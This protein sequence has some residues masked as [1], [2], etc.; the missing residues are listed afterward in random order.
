MSQWEQSQL[1]AGGFVAAK[2]KIDP[3]TTEEVVARRYGGAALGERA[4]VR[5]GADRLGPAEDLAMEYLGL[6]PRGT[7]AALGRQTKRALGF[8]N[9]ALTHHRAHAKYALQLIKR[10]KAAARRAKSKP[11]HAWDE[12]AAMADELNKSVRH[13]LPA[14]WEEAAR[15]YK[16]LGNQTYAGRSLN[17]ALEAERV[18]A[19]DVDREHRRDAVLEFTLGG[20]LSGKALSEYAA[21]LQNQFA[22]AEAFAT[23]RDLVVR[24]TLGGMAPTATMGK[25]LLRVAKA[26]GLDADAEVESVLAEI[27]ASPA[28]P[29]TP[30]QFWESVKPHVKRIVARSSQFA[31]WLLV[32]TNPQTGYS[33]DSTVWP[34]L[35]LLDEWNVLPWLSAEDLPAE[36]EIPGGRAGWIG[37]LARVES[38]PD[39]RVLELLEQMADVLR[40]EGQPV[41]LFE[42]PRW[43]RP[44]VDVDVLE[45]CLDLGLPLNDAPEQ[46]EFDFNG[47]LRAAVDHPRRNS[48]LQRVAQDERFAEHVR[49][50]IPELV[51]FTGEAA[52]SH[53]TYGR[54]LPPRRSFEEAATGHAALHDAWWQYL[55]GLLAALAA[56]GLPDAEQALASLR[57]CVGKRTNEQFPELLQRLQK[58]DLVD[59]LQRTIRAGV[60]DEY[61]WE[62]LEQAAEQHKLQAGSRR[63]AQSAQWVFPFVAYRADNQV[64]VVRPDRVDPPREL[65]LKTSQDLRLTLPVGDDVA[66]GYRDTSLGW[67]E[68]LFWLSDPTQEHEPKESLYWLNPEAIVPTEGGAFYGSRVVKPGDT[69]LPRANLFFHDGVRFWRVK[70]QVRSY[71][72]DD[73]P[74]PPT[75]A[76]IDP[77]TGKETRD[78]VPSWFEEA[79][80]A[81]ATI[82]WTVSRLLP[83]P[84][85]LTS[86]P[87]GCRD[88]LIG[89]KVMRRR[90]RSVEGHGI[91]GRRFSFRELRDR[92]QYRELVPVAMMDQP[93]GESHW[94]FTGQGLVVD[95]ASGVAIANLHGNR[96]TYCAGQPAPIPTLFLHLLRLRHEPSS[97]RLRAVSP[98]DA[99]A[100]LEAGT[101]ERQALQ[102][103]VAEGQPERTAAS[104]AIALLLPQ[105]PPR[106]VTGLARIAR[107]GAEQQLSLDQLRAALAVGETPEAAPRGEDEE[108]DELPDLSHAEASR[109]S[110]GL[111]QLEIPNPA[112][113]WYGSHSHTNNEQHLREAMLFLA[114]KRLGPLAPCD[115]PW[116]KLLRDL[117]RIAWR[118]FWRLGTIEGPTPVADRLRQPWLETLEFLAAG[119]V[120]DLPGSFRLHLASS[121]DSTKSTYYSPEANLREKLPA[122][123]QGDNRYFAQIIPA[124]PADRFHILEY[125]PQGQFR[126]PEGYNVESTDNVT[127]G[128]KTAELRA[129][130]EAV[131]GTTGL[132]YA[133][134]EQLAAA[135]EQLGVTPI[136]V[137]IIWMGNLRT[138][139]YGKDS[140]TKEIRAHYGWKTKPVQEAIAALTANPVA[141]EVVAAAVREHPSAPLAGNTAE[142]FQALVTA[143]RQ[144]QKN[145]VRLSPELIALLDKSAPRYHRAPTESLMRLLS[146]G[147]NSAMLQPRQLDFR[148]EE[149]PYGK[150]IER[151]FTPDLEGYEEGLLKDLAGTVGLINYSVPTGDPARQALPGLIDVVRRYVDQPSTLLPF[152][153]AWAVEN[154]Q[155]F[156][157][158]EVI[159][160]FSQVLGPLQPGADGIYRYDDGFLVA[161]LLP[162]YISLLFRPA[163]L[164]DDAAFQRLVAVAGQ[165]RT[166]GGTGE[167]SVDLAHAVRAL[168]SDAMSRIA[169]LNRDRALEPGVW[170]HDPRHSAPATVAAV[171][172]RLKLDEEAATYYLQLLALPDPTNANI[173][174][175]NG[176]TTKQT[177]QVA[178]PLVKA[179]RVVEAKRERAGRELFL[180]GGWEALKAPNLPLESW[181]LP[182]YGLGADNLESVR[183]RLIVVVQPIGDLFAAAWQRVKSGDAPSYEEAG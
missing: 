50:K 57:Q 138:V 144:T 54:Q 10:I 177:K 126:A 3:Q 2:S 132:P 178:A 171:R 135:S 83:L 36:P 168:R 149:R 39:K 65:T 146:E 45:A 16:D 159:G 67:Q 103:N 173:G 95:A 174:K 131:R 169:E 74:S 85:G 158:D 37:R 80:P 100:W 152:G 28:M 17:K 20:C 166:W 141:D 109:I 64:I 120:L 164:T 88:G 161:G 59:T 4:V 165:T 77:A 111:L 106:L 49:E 183:H 11:G 155:Q 137:A 86:S 46:L 134:P 156:S 142:A 145:V 51:Q 70:E 170:E 53:R 52:Q 76:E 69:T 101:A 162:P 29:R 27:I 128:W 9:W 8:A 153:E 147:A 60:L 22:P 6:E 34:W 160:K 26:A 47:W 18:H 35:D 114:G 24:R 7:S 55:A 123:V 99:K 181:K 116:L 48:Q 93:C 58:V 81:G 102:D 41:P 125:A 90:D 118:C 73:E 104:A 5:L 176:W 112:Y 15:I 33:G 84:S 110:A 71:R 121:Q 82:E 61:G 129:F 150:L 139:S 87:L 38:S 79:V 140:L 124:S 92:P 127:L 105:A 43:G 117:P 179:E 75:L 172:K 66:I 91:D 14:F 89:W 32:H 119:G 130:I 157:A 31:V 154:L 25:D 108:A 96:T 182:L 94:V 68:R 56:G 97:Q 21:D 42:K 175:W 148:L 40:R 72:I 78:S 122:W 98:A 163:R 12:F 167:K 180:P 30:L 1:D 133:T 44:R 62:A 136:E 151:H 113:S 143:W 19:L 107:L 115:L 23:L 13:F 63:G